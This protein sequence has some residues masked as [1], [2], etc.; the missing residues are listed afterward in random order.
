MLNSLIYSNRATPYRAKSGL[1]LRPVYVIRTTSL[2]GNNVAGNGHSGK[3]SL[4]QRPENFHGT[5]G[6]KTSA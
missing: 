2:N 3:H 1:V 6:T 5:R 4:H